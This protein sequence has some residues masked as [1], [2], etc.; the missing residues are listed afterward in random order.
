MIKIGETRRNAS[1]LAAAFACCA[2][3]ANAGCSRDAIE[4]VNLANEGDKAFEMNVEDA[5]SKYDRASKLDPDNNRILFKLAKAY[6]K[7]EDWPKVAATCAKAEA[8][9]EKNHKKKTFASYYFLHGYAI[10]QQATKGGAAWGDAKQ[11]FE[12]AVQIDPNLSQAYEELGE[13]Q[14]HSDDEQGAIQK[15]TK[16]IETKPDEL[17]FYPPLA[18]LYMRLNFNKEAEQVLREGLSYAKEG[19]K[20]L[21]AV[22][23][24]LGNVLE[25]KNDL[26]GSISE[27]EAAKKACG[28]C[29]DHKEAYFLLGSAY[30]AASPPRKNEAIQQLQ[31]FWKITCKGALAK[32]Y[33]D[34]C[35]Q[36]QE[37]VKR[38][39]GALQ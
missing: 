7:K 21:F 15:Y 13:V 29:D 35:S 19:D 17:Q 25:M 39:G 20:H 27:Y 28:A 24:L 1:V 32:R 12:T 34:Q 11:P 31:S 23:A 10:E 9:D 3:L 16:A 38:L 30:A 4:A 22:H 6:K 33:E 36:S 18:D 14:L 26:T 5:I 8:A 37:I 2:S